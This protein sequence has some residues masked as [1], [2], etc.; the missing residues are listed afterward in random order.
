[1]PK[2]QSLTFGVGKMGSPWLLLRPHY[3][4]TFRRADEGRAFLA[5][6]RHRGPLSSNLGA[7]GTCCQ[8][9]L[10]LLNVRSSRPL[11]TWALQTLLPVPHPGAQ[12]PT[13]GGGPRGLGKQ[14][15]LPA[16]SWWRPWRAFGVKAS[17]RS[18]PRPGTSF[19]L[20]RPLVWL[21]S[22]G[23]APSPTP[24]PSPAPFSGAHERP[25]SAR[26]GVGANPLKPDW[27]LWGV[28]SSVR[29]REQRTRGS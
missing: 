3:P 14:E 1:M 9:S 28:P 6:F 15:V 2:G 20:T 12:E 26:G 5:G 8:A 16:V 24:G 25:S 27:P 4:N 29:T 13:P 22:E 11:S 21:E 19:F 7:V 23:R 10:V 18:Y 17:S